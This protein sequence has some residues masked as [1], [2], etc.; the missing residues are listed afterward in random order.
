MI[1]FITFA[2]ACLLAFSTAAE[3]SA[4]EGVRHVRSVDDIDEYEL[5]DNG[6][7]ILL[8][9][10][11]ELPV[12][13][14]MV[15]YKV[16]S[17][18]EVSGT[19]GATHLLE[20]MM[21]KGTERFNPEDGDDYSTQMERIGARSNAST[22][23]DRTN[24]Y[25]VLPRQHIPLALKLEADRMRNLRLRDKDLASEMT[26]V[27]NEYERGE[28][29]PVQTLIKET[30]ATAFLAH[31]YGDPTIGWKPDIESTSTDK[32][33]S[34][35]D[36][37]YWP[38]NTVL[39]I[40]GGFDTE[41]VLKNAKE[42]YGGIPSSPEPIPE[43][44]TEEPEQRGP[45]R[46]ELQRHGQTG[47][48]LLSYK[49]PEGTHEDWAALSLI[50]QIAGADTTGRL[51]RALEDEGKASYSFTF[52]PR[53]RDPGL[54]TFGARLTQDVSHQEVEELILGEI[55]ALAEDGVTEDELE[56]AK[57]VV[58]AETVY[59]RDGPFAIAG[60]INEAI[61]MG[62]WT[63][64]IKHP[65][66]IQD[67]DAD[68]V[69]EVARRYFVDKR[70]TTG[71]FVP[72]NESTPALETAPL[73]PGPQ[74]FR[75]PD[76]P[77]PRPANATGSSGAKPDAGNI[78]ESKFADRLQRK[79]VAGVEVLA[80]DMP[81]EEVVSFVGSFAAGDA[82]SPSDKPAV[83]ALTAAML[84]KGTE[85]MDRFAIAKR[86]DNLGASMSFKTGNHSLGFSGRF[87]K[88]DAGPVLELLAEQLRR[89]AFD[90]E[91]FQTLRRRQTTNLLQAKDDPDY[92]ASAA[93]NRL[94]YPSDNPN[95]DHPLQE[96]ADS[97][98][99]TT[100]DEIGKFHRG[101]YGPESMLLVFAGD[102]D[103]ER[104]TDAVASSFSDWSGGKDYP[105]DWPNPEK[106]TR[107]TERIFIR[108][109]TSVAV[110]HGF[111]TG[112]RRTDEA[113]IPFMVGN[114]ILGGNF[115]SRLMRSVRQEKGLTYDIRTHH[116]GDLLTPGN[117]VLQ[118]SFSPATLQEGLEATDGVVAKWHESGV[119]NEEVEDALQTLSGS[120]LVNLST[121]S[122]VARQLHSFV[123][124]GLPP[125]Y[126]DQYAEDLQKVTPDRVNEVIQE[127]FDPAESSVVLAGT[128]DEPEASS[129][130]DETSTI[131]IRLDVPDAGWRVSIEEV[132]RKDD[133][134]FTLARLK[135]KSGPAGQV[136][137]TVSDSVET[138]ISEDLPVQHIVLGKSW[139]WGNDTGPKFVESR[140]EANAILKDAEPVRIIDETEGGKNPETDD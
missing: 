105:E 56:R 9:P 20:H 44:V 35:Y 67:V 60:A 119:T 93:L 125:D 101:F 131:S 50:R 113:Y 85:D 92:R 62:D 110:R 46:L 65:E 116:T 31:P 69:R 22:Y 127:H 25:A 13:A 23:F 106:N 30:F 41:A 36:T 63:Q 128:F 49:I 40:I 11:D 134:L 14:V 94:L 7:R 32:L 136:V 87:L 138:P 38:N 19:T 47:V 64:Y 59:G 18:N 6:L 102:I 78:P 54:F 77:A 48:V 72:D 123:Q 117:W 55:E 27:R 24:Y 28:N 124:R 2:F 122:R 95:Y 89:P 109:K 91:V 53:L 132:Y 96:L 103:F 66:A 71:W 5:E 16:G 137:S 114:F 1:R 133:Q 21:F 130:D 82:F 15:T 84:D 86:L 80:I 10:M 79:T 120:Y 45:R 39:T 33:K 34:F 4:V 97:V 90:A 98:R 3:E 129:P 108:D 83:A 51:Y 58:R 99:D 57:S 12:A 61:A 43:V 29:N 100:V 70:R 37:Y 104:L 135:R 75:A 126:I 74:N 81:A 88:E 107:E 68:E 73:L 118:A 17:R 111:Y 76:S 42:S 52:A 139:D 8:L 115:N 26:V 121:T 112:I 140:E